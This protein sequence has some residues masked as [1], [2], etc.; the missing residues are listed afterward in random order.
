MQEWVNHGCNIAWDDY[1]LL[2]GHGDYVQI[3]FPSSSPDGHDTYDMYFGASGRL[4]RVF[5][6]SEN[7]GF[8]STKSY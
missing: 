5:G 6:H 2:K 3:M 1:T 7:A 4:E 8:T